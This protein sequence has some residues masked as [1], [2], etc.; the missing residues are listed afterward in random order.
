MKQSND[1]LFA[2]TFALWNAIKKKCWKSYLSNCKKD[3][4]ID[5]DTL[6]QLVQW[7]EKYTN[8]RV[9]FL[10]SLAEADAQVAS[11]YH[12]GYGDAVM[13]YD[14]D[15]LCYGAKVILSNSRKKEYRYIIPDADGQTTFR[16]SK[17]REP[18]EQKFTRDDWIELS[19]WLG[20]DYMDPFMSRKKAI[21]NYLDWR[22][23]QDGADKLKTKK[24]FLQERVGEE[25]FLVPRAMKRNFFW[26][27]GL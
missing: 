27:P 15:Q 10:T 6:Y 1:S 17:N 14:S 3:H 21:D 23:L 7:A 19:S 25:F 9:V 11:L 24:E 2:M 13:S 22:S 26:R 4:R 16:Y 5:T 18:F 20:T 8:G 12:Q